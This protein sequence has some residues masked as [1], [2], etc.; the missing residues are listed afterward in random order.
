[1]PAAGRAAEEPAGRSPGR[2]AAAT[3]SRSMLEEIERPRS[4]PMRDIVATIQPD[5]DDIVRAGAD[6]T[7][8]VQG[9]PGTGKTAVGLHR[10][11]YLRYAHRERMGRRGVLVVGPNHA[12]LSYIRN[13]LP[14]LG[15]TEVTQVTVADLVASARTGCMSRAHPRSVPPDGP[16]RRAASRV[17]EM[18]GTCPFGKIRL[19]HPS[20][21]Q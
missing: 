17:A 20:G 8:C 1:M 10:I 19:C 6:Q 13:V 9:G 21:R 11:A 12:L 2:A 18:T 4:G 7:T 15:E 3:V 5:Q 16:A 14:A